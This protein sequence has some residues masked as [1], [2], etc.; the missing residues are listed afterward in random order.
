MSKKKK[1]CSSGTLVCPTAYALEVLG[2]VT[3]SGDSLV[4]LL[5]VVV[6]FVAAIVVVGVAVVAAIAVVGVVW[7]ATGLC[8]GRASGS[9]LVS[10]LRLGKGAGERAW[11][12]GACS[13]ALVSHL[14]REREREGEERE[15]KYRSGG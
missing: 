1:L 7:K 13:Q 2:H 4:W 5:V 15:Y 11:R 3:A 10:L 8:M 14:Q 9:D 6:A 12:K